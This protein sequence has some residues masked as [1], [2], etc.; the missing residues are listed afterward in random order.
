MSL[1][2]D[3]PFFRSQAK[4]FFAIFVELSFQGGRIE[5]LILPLYFLFVCRCNLSASQHSVVRR[6][7]SVVA[8]LHPTTKPFFA[9]ELHCR[10]K[11]I[12]VQAERRVQLL[13]HY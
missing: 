2:M 10:L 5:R 7:R 1:W 12:C 3:G 6:L 8:L 9:L 11:E 13:Q 4:E